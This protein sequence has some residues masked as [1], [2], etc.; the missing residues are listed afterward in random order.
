MDSVNALNVFVHV[1]ESGS[2]VAAGRELGISAS[3]V[4]KS[5]TRLEEH[6][7]VR[8]FRRST[9]S[10]TLTPEG[11]AFLN[12]CRRILDE[13]QAAEAELA[14]TAD[15]PKGLLR[16]SLPLMGDPFLQMLVEFQQAFPEVD[17]DLDF[18]NRNVDLVREGFDAAIRS[19]D[20]QDSNLS[21]RDIGSFR[22]VLVGSP[23]YFERKGRPQSPSDLAEHDRLGMRMPGNG[24]IMPFHFADPAWN[25]VEPPRRVPVVA[26]N[27]TTVIRFALEGAGLAYVSDFLIRADVNRGALEPVLQD[28]L[29]GG[30]NFHLVWEAGRHVSP[31]LRAFIDFASRNFLAK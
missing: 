20:Q 25:S 29:A 10:L 11:A 3:A 26:S 31:K 8:L 21:T 2:F 24:K 13:I 15:T 1:A 16:L 30:G 9:R 14:E 12:R 5:V 27:S 19:G 23:A 6:V 28:Y 7:R 4:G 22:M 17:L 18:S